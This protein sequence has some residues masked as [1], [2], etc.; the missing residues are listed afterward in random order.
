MALPGVAGFLSFPQ[1][2]NSPWTTELW[3]ES[4]ADNV[5]LRGRCGNERGPG[6]H[7]D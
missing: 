3:T 6:T 4:E 7:P 1:S 5:G 2:A